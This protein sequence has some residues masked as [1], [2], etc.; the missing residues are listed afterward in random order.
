[1]KKLELMKIAHEQDLV[2]LNYVVD[3]MTKQIEEMQD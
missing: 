1:M 3:G 2:E